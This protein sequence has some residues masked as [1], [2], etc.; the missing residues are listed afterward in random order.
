MKQLFTS[1]AIGAILTSAAVAQA[2]TETYTV[3]GNDLS[4]VGNSKVFFFKDLKDASGNQVKINTTKK[5]TVTID[6]T[7]SVVGT[8]WFD[9]DDNGDLVKR[10]GSGY[11]QRLNDTEGTY[12]LNYYQKARMINGYGLE[13]GTNGDGGEAAVSLNTPN[14]SSDKTLSWNA[15]NKDNGVIITL[16][17]DF[18]RGYEENDVIRV[19]MYDGTKGQLMFYPNDNGTA[20]KYAKTYDG[21]NMSNDGGSFGGGDWQGLESEKTC[22][23]IVLTAEAAEALNSNKYQVEVDGEGGRVHSVQLIYTAEAEGSAEVN[24]ITVTLSDET[25]DAMAE[26]ST[27]LESD[28]SSTTQINLSG[29]DTDQKEIDDWNADTFKIPAEVFANVPEGAEVFIDFEYQGNNNGRAQVQFGYGHDGVEYYYDPNGEKTHCWSTP[30]DGDNW[31]TVNLTR[32]SLTDASKWWRDK[33]TSNPSNP[34]GVLSALTQGGMFIAGNGADNY[35]AKAQIKAIYYEE[36]K[37]VEAGSKEAVMSNLWVPGQRVEMAGYDGQYWGFNN[38][39]AK[40]AFNREYEQEGGSY[41]GFYTDIAEVEKY[42]NDHSSDDLRAGWTD[43]DITPEYWSVDLPAFAPEIGDQIVVAIEA[44]GTGQNN[45]YD[46]SGNSDQDETPYLQVWSLVQGENGLEQK[47]YN[48]EDSNRGLKVMPG[49]YSENRYVYND[50]ND[51]DQIRNGYITIDLNNQTLID[52]VKNGLWLKGNLI[53]IHRVDWIHAK[54][55]EAEVITEE[56]VYHIHIRPEVFRDHEDWRTVIPDEEYAKAWKN[57]YFKNDDNVQAMDFFP[58]AADMAAGK[59]QQNQLNF[60][61]KVFV[62]LEGENVKKVRLYTYRDVEGEPTAVPVWNNALTAPGSEFFKA[63]GQSD[64]FGSQSHFKY[65][66]SQIVLNLNQFTYTPTEAAGGYQIELRTATYANPAGSTELRYMPNKT[67][68]KALEDHGLY[69][70]VHYEYQVQPTGIKARAPRRATQDNRAD[71][72]ADPVSNLRFYGE[73]KADG[74]DTHHALYTQTTTPATF[75]NVDLNKDGYGEYLPTA[76]R[77]IEDVE[78]VE[79]ANAPREV[80]NLQGIRVSEQGLTPGIYVIRQGSK[81]TKILVK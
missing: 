7:F 51:D 45:P 72:V 11:W 5:Y 47:I 76:V 3:N 13:I 6:G 16:P 31:S 9:T 65:D 53:R 66:G 4:T 61:D 74:T 26:F 15:D 41:N 60:L 34:T 46:D 10:D 36:T 44:Y 20:L 8:V 27:K 64:T 79:D 52:M 33:D 2:Q 12:T 63:L 19:W 40:K 70:E 50:A 1:I 43:P 57:F 48:W 22:F 17:G 68:V 77:E 14:N 78:A 42:F 49:G 24:S 29:Y 38:L 81:T 28:S 59:V 54:N 80:Y 56:G 62:H 71:L 55:K 58:K 69:I 25:I 18:N 75:M 37:T 67:L 23:D 35:T 21:S 30:Q 73:F 32:I 39:Q